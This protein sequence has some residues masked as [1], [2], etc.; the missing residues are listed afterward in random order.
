MVQLK[1]AVL[2]LLALSSLTSLSQQLKINSIIPSY[3]VQGDH[4]EFKVELSNISDRELTGQVQLELTDSMN[5]QSVDGWLMNT[6]PNQYF[7][8][9]AGKKEIVS[10]PIQI[11]VQFNRLL[12]WTVSARSGPG[13]D[14]TTHNKIYK[15]GILPVLTKRNEKSESY[16]LVIKD[17]SVHEFLIKKL[18]S[19]GENEAIENKMLQIEVS[20]DPSMFALI[21]LPEII[22]QNKMSTTRL[23]ETFF[24]TCVLLSFKE[25]AVLKTDK[26]NLNKDLRIVLDAIKERQMNDGAL[27][28]IRSGREDLKTTNYFLTLMGQLKFL[29][30]IPENIK[31]EIGNI[32][33]RALRYADEQVDKMIAAHTYDIRKWASYFYMRSFYPEINLKNVSGKTKMVFNSINGPKQLINKTEFF[34]LAIFLL[35]REGNTQEIKPIS[36][37]EDQSLSNL[38]A[39]QLSLL[40][41]MH[42]EMQVRNNKTADL[43]K[44][45]LQLRKENGWEDASSTISAYYSLSLLQSTKKACE[46]LI[47]LQIGSIHLYNTKEVE[48]NPISY[49]RKIIDGS[50]IKP[51][52]GS[53]N[54]SVQN[55]QQLPDKKAYAT[56]FWS[57]IEE[58]EKVKKQNDIRIKK[59]LIA[60]N[61]PLAYPTV[62]MDDTLNV[63]LEI[64]S[65]KDFGHIELIDLPP[66]GLEPIIESATNLSTY[67]NHLYFYINQLKKG[68]N[69]FEYPVIARHAGS[70]NY[71]ITN[72]EVPDKHIKIESA[73]EQ[74]ITIE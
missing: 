74:N 31:I 50:F 58:S 62:Q 25:P 48:G 65:E 1:Y 68:K 5:K 39:E 34:Q 57:Y 46:P 13:T 27:P 30:A 10:F 64:W 32:T 52:M 60:K 49:F 24:S 55:T 3:L 4:I 6:F 19:S 12:K 51:E 33:N 7:T 53:V 11:P 16:S 73:S 8:I 41:E 40:L 18:N 15:E 17:N 35:R 21:G 69:V 67:N 9:A 42:N 26:E 59:T 66:A 2:I 70:F 45:I 44:N 22:R 38:T 37:V 71:G 72:L 61:G 47:H 54:I 14:T 29:K 20:C 23:S 28:W 43:I 36:K 56:L 63:R